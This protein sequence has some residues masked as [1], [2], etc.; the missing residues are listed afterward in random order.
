MTSDVV[1]FVPLRAVV[2]VRARVEAW[3]RA[4]VATRAVPIARSGN[5]VLR[6]A[7]RDFVTVLCNF[8]VGTVVLI[9]RG[10]IFV[11]LRADM[12]FVSD[13]CA[14]VPTLP[15]RGSESD[16][17]V[18]SRITVPDVP[19]FVARE[20]V[21]VGGIFTELFVFARVDDAGVAGLRR[22]AARAMSDASSAT[23]GYN[24]SGAKNMAKNSLIPFI[25]VL[26]QTNLSKFMKTRASI[27]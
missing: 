8:C 10:C 24:T 4:D 27:K 15:L 18:R 20:A 17:M 23:A 3:A 25:L 5:V 22:V 1:V 2:A 13:A 21:L 14:R 19:M 16:V 9:T 7:V 6:V 12:F 11:V 26:V